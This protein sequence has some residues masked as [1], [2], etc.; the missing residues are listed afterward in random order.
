[1]CIIGFVELVG[2]RVFEQ[3]S[4]KAKPMKFVRL[5]REYPLRSIESFL[6]KFGR[7]GQH[8]KRDVIV[9]KRLGYMQLVKVGVCQKIKSSAL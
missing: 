1:M 2:T 9:Q 3:L 4:Q 7:R 8:I 6:H 5:R